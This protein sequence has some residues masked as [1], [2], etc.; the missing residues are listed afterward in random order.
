MAQ[1]EIPFGF[2]TETLS[3]LCTQIKATYEYELSQLDSEDWCRIKK[4]ECYFLNTVTSR[5]MV[6][7][8]NFPKP[9]GDR[10]AKLSLEDKLRLLNW[11]ILGNDFMGEWKSVS[12]S[13]VSSPLKENILD[14]V[15]GLCG[16]YSYPL[17]QAKFT[18]NLSG[19]EESSRSNY[20]IRI[21]RDRA[22]TVSAAPAKPVNPNSYAAKAATPAKAETK[23]A[24]VGA[25]EPV[26]RI[27]PVS[28]NDA[29]KS[30]V[31]PAALPTPVVKDV[32][33]PLMEKAMLAYDDS[34]A[35]VDAVVAAIKHAP[36]TKEQRNTIGAKLCKLAVEMV[37]S[38][39][40]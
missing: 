28:W 34:R 31:P 11:A 19:D 18:M 15:K 33:S 4:L 35:F 10:D 38:A 32:T 25:G 26:L 5:V 20:T 3:D 12:D 14:Y 13:G 7:K 36:L 16:R 40:S 2:S 30:V 27:E 17:F 23:P 22:M 1:S 9:T 39:A 6:Q 8:I 21:K 24:N 37:A 29:A